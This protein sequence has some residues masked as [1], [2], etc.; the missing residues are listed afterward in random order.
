VSNHRRRDST[1]ITYSVL[2]AAAGGQRKTRIMYQSALNLKQ[3]N[4]YLQELVESELLGYQPAGRFYFT[5]EKGRAFARAFEHIHETN[6][7]LREQERSLEKLLTAKAKKTA[8]V[9]VRP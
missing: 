7:L 3:L 1:E 2:K 4:L 5:T 8:A 6:D 9:E